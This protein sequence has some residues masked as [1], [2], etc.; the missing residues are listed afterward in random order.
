M[1]LPRWTVYPALAVLTL[2]VVTAVPH[3]GDEAEHEGAAARAR[4]LHRKLEANRRPAQ[5]IDAPMGGQAPAEREDPNDD[6]P[7]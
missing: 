4:E 3:T 2:L 1:R 7:R 6:A 5:A